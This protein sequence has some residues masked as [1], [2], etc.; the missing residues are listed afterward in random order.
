M[1][2]T[3]IILAGGLG[4][5][6]RPLTDETPKP[7]LNVHGKPIIEHTINNLKKH[8]VNNIILSIGY[9]ADKIQDYFGDGSRL[10]VNVSYCIENEPLG[11]GGAIKEA[12]KNLTKPFIA[13]N[14]DN[15]SDFDFTELIKTHQENATP[16]TLTLF[17]VEDVTQYGIADLDGNKISGFIEKPSVE[18]APSNL[19]NA[20][21]YVIDPNA[22][23]ILPEGKS[24][25]ERDCFEK[26]ARQGQMGAYVH[27]G[28]WFPTD[29]LKKFTDACRKF[30][31]DI[32]F[33]K[34]KVLICDVDQTVCDS[35]QEMSE[36]MAQQIDALITKGYS[37]AFISGTHHQELQRMISSKL[38]QEHHILATTGTNYLQVKN[39]FA[40]SKY[41]LSLSKEEKEIIFNA[42]NKLIDE[43]KLVPLTSKQDQLQDRDSQI[44]LS[45]LGRNAPSDVKSG[46]DP[47]GK[48]R[49]TMVDYLRQLLNNEKFEM[50][51]GG[52]TS[53]DITKKGLDKEWGIKEFAKYNDIDINKIVFFGDKIY[54]GGNDYPAAKI[55]DCVSVDS[56][57]DAL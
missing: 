47:D 36:S 39:K 26:L 51:I 37:F 22:L 25:I 11:T 38:N 56:P 21:G 54:P 43:F 50:K 53:I 16:I 15:L 27:Q 14:G 13:L 23:T 5:R 30:R 12:S 1:I 34:K 9:R 41:N 45:I 48:R 35:C 40:H 28:Q 29:T 2:D 4:T 33:S 42:F 46:Y 19:N 49:K 18:Q 55:V 3:A 31:S 24:S 17:P 44:T 10:G 8:G 57:R 20:G 52:T 6:L 32:N 7:L